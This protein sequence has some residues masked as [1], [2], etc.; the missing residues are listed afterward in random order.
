MEPYAKKIRMDDIVVHR[1][2]SSPDYQGAQRYALERLERDLTPSLCY[3]SLWHTRDEVALRARWLAEYEGLSPEVQQLICSAACFHD[4]G[5]MLDSSDH[6]TVSARI[7]AEILPEYGF[8]PAHISLVQGMIMATRVPQR[9]RNHLEEI[10][11]D[12]DLDVLGR[13]DFFSRNL[14]LRVEMSK[15]GVTT[16]DAVWYSKQLEFMHQH[17]YFTKTAHRQRYPMKQHNIHQLR[18]II[19]DCCPQADESATAAI[20]PRFAR[21]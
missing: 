21:L 12:A 16:S 10:L 13:N 20:G 2:T 5:F 15:A 14:A 1:T 7:A 3:H 17:R 4:I 8:N 18:K 19:S 9:P 11:A 6:E